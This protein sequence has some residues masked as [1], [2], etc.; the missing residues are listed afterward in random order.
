MNK[1]KVQAYELLKGMATNNYQCQVI[2]LCQI[3]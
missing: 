2:E 1:T 3:K